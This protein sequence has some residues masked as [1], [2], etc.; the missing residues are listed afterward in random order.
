MLLICEMTTF[1]NLF[2]KLPRMGRR[3]DEMWTF[4]VS[5]YSLIIW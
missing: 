2:G 4:F 5:F 3:L 1:D